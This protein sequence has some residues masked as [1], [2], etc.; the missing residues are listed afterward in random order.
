MILK[1]KGQAA[2]E[3]LMT[4]GWALLVVLIVIAALAFFGLL[5]PSRYL[6]EKCTLG[7]G[8]TCVDFSARTN[9][10]DESKFEG[11]VDI[12]KD[13]V[14]ILLNNGIGTTMY[15]VVLSLDS[16]GNGSLD[17]EEVGSLGATYLFADDGG[18][19]PVNGWNVSSIPSGDTFKFE[20]PCGGMIPKNKFKSEM[21]LSYES[22]I[23][24]NTVPH[25]KR[26]HV[27]VSVEQTS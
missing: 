3:F 11:D 4:Y 21:S 6:P 5:N 19:T 17:D 13:T 2:M 22:R 27:T 10:S 25:Q 16:C 8:L 20:F 7:P 23:E 9:D 12:S 24:S 1:R 14:T 18:A 26:G 15:N